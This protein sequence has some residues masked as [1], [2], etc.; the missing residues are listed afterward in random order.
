MQVNSVKDPEQFHR[1]IENLVSKGLDY[2]E[3]IVHYCE[4]N[5]LE[6]E[7]V[8]PVMRQSVILKAKLQR[9]AEGLHLIQKSNTLPI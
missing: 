2:L 9:E 8:V 3:A 6:I 4:V 7:S 5:G 1:E